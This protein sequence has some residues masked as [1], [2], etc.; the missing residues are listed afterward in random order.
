M[1]QTSKSTFVVLFTCLMLNFPSVAQIKARYHFGFIGSTGDTSAKLSEPVIIDYNKCFDITNGVPKFS[2]PKFGVFAVDCYEA[3]P[4]ISLLVHAY[5]NPVVSQLTIRS[6]NSYPE[7]SSVK[8]KVVLTDIT[9]NLLR[10]L[11]TD[12]SQINEGFSIRVNDLSFGYFIVTLYG[13][14]ERIQSFKILKA[15]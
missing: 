13:N 7:N 12:L 4:R 9:G 1:I 8:Y 14:N 3:K 2:Q 11:K 15:A 10:E 5:P 6:L